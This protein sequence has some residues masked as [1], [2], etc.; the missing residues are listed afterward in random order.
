MTVIPRSAAVRRSAA[1]AVLLAAVALV[2]SACTS[3][4]SGSGNPKG[5]PTVT[6]TSS[7]S[8]STS[9]APSGSGSTS[10]K[11]DV[12]AK[13]VHISSLES[14]GS[15]WGIGMPIILW[16]NVAPTSSVDF[17]KNTH[18][19]VNGQPATGAWF[20]QK[21]SHPGA[22]IE[23]HYREQGF[24]PGHATIQV[25]F[26]PAGTSA[27][28][29][30]AFDGKLTS[31][32]MRTGPALIGEVNGATSKL[33]VQEDGKQ[34]AVFPVA[35]GAPN[36]PTLE[37]TKLVMYKGRNERMIGSG[38]NEIVPWSMRLTNSGEYL[39]AAAWNIPNVKA[40]RPSSN[41]CTN[42]LPADAQRL[43]GMVEYGDP[44]IY[45]NIPGNNVKKTPSWDGYGDWNLNWST[46][47][48][49][50]LLLNH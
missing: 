15:Q 23:A 17:V 13:P 27:G 2:A 43:F 19:T 39:H 14:D 48:Q 41:G 24:W 50:G 46:W 12:N 42:M 9:T 34:V 11:T 44:F 6:V 25:T 26:P 21:S 7:P 32:T 16:F 47:K 4:S 49:G 37:G 8:G 20:W 28:S 1:L 30:L 33:T 3:S 35:L 29:G 40:G 22:A 18:V 38:Y 5:E 10:P 31:L 36:T 45:T